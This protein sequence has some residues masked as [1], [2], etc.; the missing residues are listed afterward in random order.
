MDRSAEF[1]SPKR[2]VGDILAGTPVDPAPSSGA[3]A[4]APAIVFDHVTVAYGRGKKRAEA[5]RNFNLRIA[6]GETVALLGPSGS[7]KS[8]ALKALAGFVRPTFGTVRL[9]G[10]D[11]TDLP[12][13]KRGIGV[14]VQS[15][16]LFPHMRVRDN[17]AFGLRARRTKSGHI[18]ARVDEALAMVSMSSYADRYP[19][20]LSGG[21][22]Q[23]VAIARAL[24][25]RPRVLLLDEP[26]AALDAQLR[27]SMVAELQQLQKTLSDTAMLYVTHDQSEALALADRIAV[28]RN[29]ELV[30]VDTARNLWT[31][32]PSDF[33]ANFLGGANLIPCTVGRVSGES[34]LVSVGD[35]VLSVT[36]PKPEVGR[37]PWAPGANAMVCIRPHALSVVAASEPGALRAR[38]A[39]QVWRGAS[40]RL[41]LA[42][43]GFPDQLIDVD[44]PGHGEFS[45]DSAVG[46]KFPEPAGVLVTIPGEAE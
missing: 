26:L 15:Y 23:R 22:Q 44:V 36:A 29:A 8:T 5:L 11:V 7:G 1:S 13:A 24:A 6:R 37:D 14:V 33:T 19:R 16:A 27:Q 20:E 43:N 35:K 38:V 46:V 28:M 42:V 30:D 2:F 3:I 45:P 21:Q 12:P 39:T 40:T 10:Q 17:V 32:P 4:D 31:R 34:A 9:D 41:S 18:A 25:I